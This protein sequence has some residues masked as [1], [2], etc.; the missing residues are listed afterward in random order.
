[1]ALVRPGGLL[2]TCS[3]SGAMTQSG[4]FISHLQVTQ[5]GMVAGRTAG[6]TAL[7]CHGR[8]KLIDRGLLQDWWSWHAFV[9]GTDRPMLACA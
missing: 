3:C 6:Q 1:M 2:M 8:L 7:T 4:E 5:N 9:L